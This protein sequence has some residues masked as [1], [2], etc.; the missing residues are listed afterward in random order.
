MVFINWTALLMNFISL[1]TK[2]ILFVVSAF[3]IKQ[4]P[5]LYFFLNKKLIKIM[6]CEQKQL[7][8]LVAIE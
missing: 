7:K 6:Y 1:E 2:Y 3:A 4:N 8:K 5:I